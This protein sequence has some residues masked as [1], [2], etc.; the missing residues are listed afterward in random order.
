MKSIVLS[1]FYPESKY[2][3]KAFKAG[4]DTLVDHG[5]KKIEFCYYG[6]DEE[7]V[8]E[9]LLTKGIKSIYL[10]AIP[11][12]EKKLSLS[13]L[14]EKERSLAVKEAIISIKKAYFYESSSILINSG[15]K[16]DNGNLDRAK[17]QLKKSLLELNN[18]AKENYEKDITINL[19]TGDQKVDFFETLGPTAEA[20]EF[21]DELKAELSNLFLT[22]DT[23]HLRQLGEDT[24]ESLRM[25][26][27][28]CNH[29]HFANCILKDKTSPL[30]GDKHPEFG[31]KNGEFNIEDMK[32]IYKLIIDLY[33]DNVII[34]T[35]IIA[36]EHNRE[37]LILDT[38]SN[39]NWLY[40]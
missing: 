34:G 2:S 14:N 10:G 1:A 40:S 28:H 24:K 27:K 7:K 38:I 37:K 3:F 22:L 20:I 26:V 15:R 13:S 17:F 25:G 35:E 19:E 8:R 9:L 16:P 39:F 4:I 33:K 18:Y 31:V 30:F 23:S 5:I 12:K 36:R 6:E 29:I 11:L 21:V 32:E